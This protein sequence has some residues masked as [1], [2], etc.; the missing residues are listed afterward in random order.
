MGSWFGK[1]DTAPFQLTSGPM[2]FFDALPSKDGK[3]LFVV[4]ALARGELTRYDMKSATFAPFLSGISADGVSFS[5]DGQWVTYVSYPDTTLWKSKADGSQRIQLTFPPLAAELPTWSPDGKQIAFY[6]M[7][8]GKKVK[9]NTVAADGGTP[10]ELMPEDPQDQLD[11]TWSADGS[12][13]R[14]PDPGP[15]YPPNLDAA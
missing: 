8:P 13:Q 12:Q 15:R 7:L 11:A 5:R 4:G 1:A 3:K 6:G 2:T 10:R 14:H 9:L